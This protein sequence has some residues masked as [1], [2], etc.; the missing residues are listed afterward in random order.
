MN[1]GDVSERCGVPAKTIRYYE[2]I[3]LVTPARSK[4]GYREFS[5]RDIH[6]LAFVGR[7]RSVG[8]SIEACRTLLALYEK[9]GLAISDKRTIASDFIVQIDQKIAELDALAK[10]FHTLLERGQ[11]GQQ[12]EYMFVDGLEPRMVVGREKQPIHACSQKRDKISLEN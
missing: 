11:F 5:Q 3:G 4:C 9:R 7:A 12:V 6:S 1:I 10:V 2:D 8:F